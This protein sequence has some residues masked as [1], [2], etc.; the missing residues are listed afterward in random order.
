MSAKLL[1]VDDEPEI[2]S[3]LE[4]IIESEFELEILKADSGNKAIEVLGAN[5]DVSLIISDYNMDD[6]TGGDLF[7]KVKE[8]SSPKPFLLLS[9]GYIEDYPEFE[10]FESVNSLNKFLEKPADE[11][12]IFEFIKASLEGSEESSLLEE[13][14]YKRVRLRYYKEFFK[15]PSDLY[16]KL[17]S[18][19][20][21]QIAKVE[22]KDQM[23]I[24][25]HYL[26]K[27]VDFIYMPVENYKA[28][29]EDFQNALSPEA[30]DKAPP[31]KMIDLLGI[32]YSVSKDDL[33]ALGVSAMHTDLVNKS[34][35]AV[36][37]DL[38][39]NKGLFDMLQKFFGREDYLV[40]H[41][42][43]NIYFTSY[44][45]GKLGWSNEQTLQQL[46][47]ASFF[48]DMTLEDND[49]AKV[50]DPS[51]IEDSDSK[52]RILNHM[53]K[54][55]ELLDG[56]QGIN[57]DARKIILDHHEL[58]DGTG[59]PSGLNSSNLPPLSCAFILSHKIVEYLIENKFR[60]GNLAS[61]LQGLQG[62]W[63]Q[64]NFKR[65]F[66]CARQILLS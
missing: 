29:M 47:Y 34:L 15:R 21:V 61:F 20:F 10:N 32:T 45:L 42:V 63:D 5:S 11:E 39:G 48:H 51:A 31:E 13:T 57:H 35:G 7:N 4:I 24:L 23:E 6:G 52:K 33:K 18:K 55:A 64:G 54:G 58:P 14:P 12:D 59:F 60:T 49:L 62:V 2:L 17:P 22:N 36:I 8:D 26:E 53:E 56:L 19:K 46:A 65:P 9:A 40:D 1:L 25:E 27:K 38:S 43:L 3:L 41:S 28:F 44:I 50:D 66:E 16:I 37:K 30:L